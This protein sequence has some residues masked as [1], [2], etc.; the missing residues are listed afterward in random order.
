MVQD[1]TPSWQLTSNQYDLTSDYGTSDL[2]YL[3]NLGDYGNGGTSSGGSSLMTGGGFLSGFGN[4]IGSF[5]TGDAIPPSSGNGLKLVNM[6]EQ[7]LSGG[8]KTI[9]QGTALSAGAY[10]EAGKSAISGSEF[11][12]KVYRQAG[13][14]ATL[15]ANYNIGVDQVKTARMQDA[16]GRELTKTIST[17]TAQAAANGLSLGSRST[18]AVQSGIL[19]AA[20]RQTLQIANDAKQR[21]EMIDYQGKLTQ[22]NYENQALAAEYSGKVAAQQYENQARMA[23]YQGEVDK[24]KLK[25]DAWKEEIINQREEYMQDI[26]EYNIQVNQYNQKNQ[27]RGQ[28]IGQAFGLLGSFL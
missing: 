22:V 9:D 11:E 26:Q 15:A 19:D 5:M 7:L 17:N 4:L 13:I 3:Q 16:L 2:T 14:Q 21:Q 24:Y 27:Q 10:R 20:Q 12:A 1:Y 18:M 6:G 23:E 8:M 25:V 28:M